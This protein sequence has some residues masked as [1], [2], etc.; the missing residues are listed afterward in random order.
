VLL[1]IDSSFLYCPL[2]Y[3]SNEHCVV[4]LIILDLLLQRFYSQA[5]LLEQIDV[6]ETDLS[7]LL[8]GVVGY[9]CNC[10]LEVWF[11]VLVEK[12]AKLL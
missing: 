10:C 3:F 6:L 12:M 4:S 7:N 1:S 5:L 8:L 11:S 9:A 2:L